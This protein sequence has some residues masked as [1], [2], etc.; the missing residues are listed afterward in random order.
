MDT[1]A[2]NSST[3]EER[4]LAMNSIMTSPFIDGPFLFMRSFYPD[5]NQTRDQVI[6]V[7]NENRP[8]LART[9]YNTIEFVL[10]DT[11]MQP[12]WESAKYQSG[13]PNYRSNYHRA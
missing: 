9:Y 3:T 8:S 10:P 2:T 11:M 1:G 4:S 12:T 6:F 7:N 13:K 5:G